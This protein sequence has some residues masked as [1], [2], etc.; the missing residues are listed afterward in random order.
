[1]FN[2]CRRF[3]RDCGD[4]HVTPPPQF[5]NMAEPT[6]HSDAAAAIAIAGTLVGVVVVVVAAERRSVSY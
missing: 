3:N 4:D 5:S 1:M 6:A 2:D